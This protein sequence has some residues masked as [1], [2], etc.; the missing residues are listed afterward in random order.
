MFQ[1]S[2]G[3]AANARNISQLK[4]IE[5]VLGLE[6][7]VGCWAFRMVANRFLTGQDSVGDNLYATSFFVQLELRD[8]TRIGSNAVGIL[9]QNVIDYSEN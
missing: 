5:G 2:N 9:K 1:N 7:K 8:I 3:V 6:Y 4:L